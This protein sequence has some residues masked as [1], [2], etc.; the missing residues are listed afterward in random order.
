MGRSGKNTF[1]PPAPGGTFIGIKMSF[2]R[3]VTV[4]KYQCVCNHSSFFMMYAWQQ[5]GIAATQL[6]MSAES[7][8]MPFQC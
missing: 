1:V 8:Q 2:M 7:S 5:D 4:L 3:T 6:F